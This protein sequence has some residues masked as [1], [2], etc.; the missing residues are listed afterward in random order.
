MTTNIDLNKIS[1]FK[2][3]VGKTLREQ[4]QG[5]TLVGAEVVDHLRSFPFYKKDRDFTP[6]SHWDRPT[7]TGR[8]IYL[9]SLT[10]VKPESWCAGAVQ[11]VNWARDGFHVGH[12][13]AFMGDVLDAVVGKGWDPDDWILVEK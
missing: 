9:F 1:F 10:Y 2:P 11:G 3:I 12:R 5:K 4:L 13:R 8:N 6:P 7:D